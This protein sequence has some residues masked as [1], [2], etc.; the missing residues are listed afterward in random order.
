MK[1]HRKHWI[2]I[3]GV[4][5]ALLVMA[6][7]YRWLGDD[8][9]AWIAAVVGEGTPPL[10]FLLLYF[11]LPLIGF[12][13]SVFLVLIGVK[14]GSLWGVVV[15]FSGIAAHL[16][17]IF[18][19]TNSVLRAPIQRKLVDLGYRLPQIPQQRP[20]W[21][22]C[23][24]MAVPGLPYTVKNYALALCGVPFG[25]FFLSGFLFQG[26]MGVP[27]VIAG[28]ALATEQMI[29]LAA[30]LAAITGLAAIG[31]HFRKRYR[32]TASQDSPPEDA[33]PRR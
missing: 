32:Q 11:L 28:D 30:I 7:A 25:Y 19:V 9:S 2:G 24:F 18:L 5:A 15:L 1:L 23:I 26:L 22:S 12:P 16:G 8:A 27:F 17:V 31:N 20:L 13:I 10:L 4:S 14:F 3:A 6:A 21:F 33:P 29:L